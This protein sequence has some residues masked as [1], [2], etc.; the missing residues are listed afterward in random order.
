MLQIY[1]M[2]KPSAHLQVIAN[3]QPGAL[4]PRQKFLRRVALAMMQMEMFAL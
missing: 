4:G 2:L 1:A 3:F